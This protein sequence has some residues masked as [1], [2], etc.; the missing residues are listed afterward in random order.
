MK[1][2]PDAAA[3]AGAVG[4]DEGIQMVRKVL[5][6]TLIELLVVIA[7]IAI[8]AAIL[9]PVFLA[10]QAAAK[11]TTCLSNLGQMGKGM[12]MYLQ[13]WAYM[14]TWGGIIGERQGGWCDQML[15]YTGKSKG[16]L[17]CPQLSKFPGQ[18]SGAIYPT[19]VMNW[20]LTNNGLRGAR[21]DIVPQ[22]SKLI[23]IWELN[24]RPTAYTDA[25]H[26]D[27]FP[28]WDKT[29]ERQHDSDPVAQDQWWWFKVPGPHNG[30]LNTLFLDAHVKSIKYRDP[31]L[32]L[33]MP[34]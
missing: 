4:I 13:D 1:G 9:F 26:R 34:Q 6:F 28:D 14:P 33:D 21:V 32:K 25:E 22:P 8:L 19:Y 12:K 15:K 31:T 18:P 20:Q 16:I 17:V 5:G 7:I 30:A 10:A 23:A 29:N 24:R 3:R 2:L 27:C 11:S